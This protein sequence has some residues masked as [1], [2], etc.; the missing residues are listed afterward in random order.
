MFKSKIYVVWS[1]IFT[2]IPRMTRDHK[3][4]QPVTIVIRDFWHYKLEWR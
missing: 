3:L 2:K 4:L 1:E